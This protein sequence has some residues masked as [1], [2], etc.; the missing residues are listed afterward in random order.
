MRIQK[1]TDNLFDKVP[2]DEK[3]II[4]G[5][6]PKTR[7]YVDDVNDSKTLIDKHISRQRNALL[8]FLL[9]AIG[10]QLIVII[11]IFVFAYFDFRNKI[12]NIDEY[13]TI[14]RQIQIFSGLWICQA[15]GALYYIAKKLY[16]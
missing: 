12:F 1:D 15:I 11:V 13:V 10:I 3:A 16:D 6:N 8:A 9:S 5:V 2:T 4:R 7:Y 14:I